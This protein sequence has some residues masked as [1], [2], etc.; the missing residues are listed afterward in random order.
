MSI[1]PSTA[2]TIDGPTAWLVVDE[3]RVLFRKHAN[4]LCDTCNGYPGPTQFEP[5]TCCDGTGRHTFTLE[6][7]PTPC[8][9]N[10]DHYIGTMEWCACF[11][12]IATVSVHVVE[13]LPIVA[14]DIVD[15]GLPHPVPCMTIDPHGN[16][17]EADEAGVDWFKAH[18][19][20]LPP[21]A[22]VGMFCV[23]LAVHT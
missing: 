20:T 5:R 12:D 10:E 13:V 19:R 2:I 15:L 6:V 21:D 4:R 22:A 8:T 14:W 16:A 1:I 9:I 11:P 7:K 3:S 18:D 23:R 17:L